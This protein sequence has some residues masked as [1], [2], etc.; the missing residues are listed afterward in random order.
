M[1]VTPQ[2]ETTIKAAVV[3]QPVAASLN[4]NGIK[5][6][7]SGVYTETITTDMKCN[8]DNNHWMTLIG[9]GN[10]DKHDYWKFKNSWGTTWG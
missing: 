6:Y 8:K 7:K 3:H 2:N 5:N 9:Y 1:K 4:T 10:A